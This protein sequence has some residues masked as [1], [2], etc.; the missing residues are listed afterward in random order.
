MHEQ[1]TLAG[2]VAR[3]RPSGW[4][5]ASVVAVKSSPAIFGPCAAA[6]GRSPA[7]HKHDFCGAKQENLPLELTSIDV[8]C[9]N[10]AR[11]FHESSLLLFFS[12]SF[13]SQ[14]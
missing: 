7:R 1:A 8:T 4:P 6:E 10:I 3:I 12:S 9:C 5:S 14:S 11:P 13:L 2:G